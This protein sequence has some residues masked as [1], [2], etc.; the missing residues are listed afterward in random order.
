[1]IEISPNTSIIIMNIMKLN[2]LSKRQILLCYIKTAVC[3]YDLHRRNTSKT[4]L[5]WSWNK[6]ELD[7]NIKNGNNILQGKSH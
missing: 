6:N 1:M 2:S 7:S 5:K 4:L 3:S